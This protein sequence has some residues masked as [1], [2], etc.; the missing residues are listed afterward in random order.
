MATERY[1]KPDPVNLGSSFEIST[2]ELAKLISSLVGFKGSI[3]FDHSKPDGQPRRK[4]DTMRAEREFGFKSKTT[5][6]VGLAKT[7]KWYEEQ[8]RP[9]IEKN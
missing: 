7:I 3:T 5:F 8:T 6:K 4:L 9:K 1:N 2:G